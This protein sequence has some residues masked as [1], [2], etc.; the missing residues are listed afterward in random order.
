MRRVIG[1]RPPT[2][3]DLDSLTFLRGVVYETLQLYP[4]GVIS[5]RRFRAGNVAALRPK[6]GLTVQITD[7][8]PAQ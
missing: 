7:S 3:T 1:E 5:A 2:T 8:A 6:P 4:S